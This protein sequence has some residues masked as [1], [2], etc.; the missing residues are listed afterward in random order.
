[1]SSRQELIQWVNDLL[2]LNYTKVEQLGA[3]AAYAQII[4][5]VYGNVPMTK[6]NFAARQEYEYLVN[7]KVLQET[8]KRNKIDKVSIQIDIMRYGA[9][10]CSSYFFSFI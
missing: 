2:L 5:S 6:L 3:G 4:D 8:F 1:M 10:S 9:N 7:Y